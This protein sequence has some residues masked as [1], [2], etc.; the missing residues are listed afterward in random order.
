MTNTGTDMTDSALG[1]DLISFKYSKFHKLLQKTHSFYI[2]H[3]A[4]GITHLLL[5]NHKVFIS[6][7]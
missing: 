7:I 5:H 3:S 6:T 1:C 4:L 2:R